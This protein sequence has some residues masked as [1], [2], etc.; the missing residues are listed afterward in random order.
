MNL[1][2]YQDRQ[3]VYQVFIPCAKA[4]GKNYMLCCGND[5]IYGYTHREAKPIIFMPAENEDIIDLPKR[6][7][8]RH[9]DESILTHLRTI[10]RP[11]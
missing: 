2:D 1:R 9:G 4:L 6:R 8:G 5:A 7:K 11:A 10:P 3:M